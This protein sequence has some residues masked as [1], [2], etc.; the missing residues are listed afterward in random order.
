MKKLFD[1]FIKKTNIMKKVK[2]E[3]TAKLPTVKRGKSKITLK[4][5]KPSQILIKSEQAPISSK[6]A[7]LMFKLANAEMIS[8]VTNPNDLAALQIAAKSIDAAIKEGRPT[9][10][11]D[12][13]KHIIN[14]QANVVC[15][16][17][18]YG[19]NPDNPRNAFKKVKVSN[20][21]GSIEIPDEGYYK[22]AR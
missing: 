3:I 19:V 1:F 18:D 17:V 15:L 21:A 12:L 9:T 4:I 13:N 2:Q 10:E 11:S 5:N 22:I 7:E 6:T 20:T 8:R 14:A 16:I